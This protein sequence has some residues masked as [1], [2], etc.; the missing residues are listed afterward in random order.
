MIK[1]EIG[2]RQSMICKGCADSEGDGGHRVARVAMIDREIG[3]RQSMVCKGC[4]DS[5]GDGGY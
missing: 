5:E 3:R 1:R 4:A 2:R